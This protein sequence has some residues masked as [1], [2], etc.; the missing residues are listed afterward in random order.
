MD[1]LYLGIPAGPAI[2]PVERTGLGRINR[3]QPHEQPSPQQHEQTEDD[4]FAEEEDEELLELEPLE[5]YDDHGRLHELGVG[6]AEPHLITGHPHAGLPAVIEV[7]DAEEVSGEIVESEMADSETVTAGRE[8]TPAAPP[9]A[10]ERR[11]HG[12][13]GHIDISV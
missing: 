4:E 7:D 5:T 11:H 6:D 8:D 10:G 13:D 2:P 1:P 12:S 3:N 9:A